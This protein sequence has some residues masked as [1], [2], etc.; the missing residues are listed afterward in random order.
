MPDR[1]PARWR[2]RWQLACLILAGV[3][4]ASVASSKVHVTYWEKWTGFE[5]DGMQAIVDEFNESQDQ[6]YVEYLSI[7]QV[8]QKTLVDR[9]RAPARYRWLMGS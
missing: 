5:K 1:R 7:S 9:G 4:G 8:N 6:I 2:I 3:M